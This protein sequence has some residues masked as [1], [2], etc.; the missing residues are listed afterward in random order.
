MTHAGYILAAWLIT[1]AVLG[2]YTLSV[3]SRGRKLGRH[4]PPEKSRWSTTSDEGANQ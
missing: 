1:F 4:V 2:L 3:L